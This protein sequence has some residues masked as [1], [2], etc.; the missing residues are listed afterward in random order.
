MHA[1]AAV[2]RGRASAF[3]CAARQREHSAIETA[4]AESPLR[5]LFPR[6]TFAAGARPAWVC[7]TTLGGGFVKGDAIDID[8]E[9][10]PEATLLMTTQASTKIFRGASRQSIRAKVAGTLVVLMDPVAC[11]KDA[12]YTQRA[13]IE[14]ADGGSVI[15]VESVT[16]GRPAFETPF[17]F[18][19]YSSKIRIERNGDPL[20][21]DAV[22]LDRTHGS[23]AA[24]FERAGRT[25]FDTLTTI[26]A[27]GSAAKLLAGDLLAP[28]ELTR[29]GLGD[30]AVAPTT[31]D[32]AH[33]SGALVRIA[34]TSSENAAGETRRR[35][36]NLP[37]ILM[38]DPF[39]F[40]W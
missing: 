6:P 10:K 5:F 31:L 30:I 7:L 35:L 13:D 26:V 34:A 20:V 14:L 23:I 17:S 40:R 36:R 28:A 1:S 2:A 11:F 19:K 22:A 4:V 29:D 24:R 8:V 37:E 21:V 32:A 9:V 12:I 16:S 27:I 25:A 38:V 15:W 39:A 3:I 18:E 33:G